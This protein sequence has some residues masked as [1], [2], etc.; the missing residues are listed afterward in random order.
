MKAIV[1]YSNT[2]STKEYAEMISNATGIPNMSLK[3]AKKN[4]SKDDD[5]IWT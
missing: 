1:Y 3:E 4:L 2:G 5:I